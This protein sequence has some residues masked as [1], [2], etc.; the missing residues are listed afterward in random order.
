ME[1][2]YWR[3]SNCCPC[4]I[5]L[6]EHV[7]RRSVELTTKAAIGQNRKTDAIQ[8]ILNVVYAPIAGRKSHQPASFH[9]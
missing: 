8:K 9:Q 5:T 1:N 6:P 2:L 4:S 7:L 3:L